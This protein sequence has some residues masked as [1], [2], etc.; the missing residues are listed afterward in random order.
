[1]NSHTVQWGDDLYDRYGDKWAEGIPANYY[2]FSI[3]Y[4]E[5]PVKLVTESS[6]SNTENCYSRIRLQFFGSLGLM[7][8]LLKFLN[9][10]IVSVYFVARILY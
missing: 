9:L 4:I 1:M 6:E 7:H 3:I 2:G 8:E 5:N 10:L